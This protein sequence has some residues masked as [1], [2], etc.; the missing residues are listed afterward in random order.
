MTAQ[1]RPGSASG[2]SADEQYRRTG[3]RVGAVLSG[4]VLVVANVATLFFAVIAWLMMPSGPGDSNHIEGALFT[5]FAGTVLAVL[6]V[7]L[8]IIPVA[9]RWLGKKWFIVPA[10]LFVLATARWIYIDDAYPEPPDRYRYGSAQIS[11]PAV[12]GSLAGEVLP[13]RPVCA[14][15]P[16]KPGNS[17]HVR[18]PPWVS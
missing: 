10:V 1:Q 17:G 12:D 16:G 2:H 4:V 18:H 9:A 7:L 3:K 8:T 6:A 15:G 14:T 11:V 13:A 5:A